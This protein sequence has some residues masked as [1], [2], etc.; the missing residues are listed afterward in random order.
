MKHIFTPNAPTPGAY[1][2]GVLDGRTLSLSGQT[3]NDPAHPKQDIVNGGVGPQTM[4]AL[5]NLLA[6][7]VAAGGDIHSFVSLRVYLKD[8]S[9]SRAADNIAEGR[10]QE[11]W[12]TYNKAY[13]AFFAE[14]GRNDLPAR[15]Q[16]WVVDIPLPNEPTL[17]EVSGIAVISLRNKK[18][19]RG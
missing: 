2:Q 5:E 7:V 1:S 14:H 17:V 8:S 11:D 9:G 18:K 10:R 19:T 4:Q 3:G 16:V 15:E 12:V 6:V 13:R